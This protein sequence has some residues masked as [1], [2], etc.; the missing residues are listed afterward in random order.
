M[1]YSSSIRLFNYYYFFRY[2]FLDQNQFSGPLPLDWCSPGLGSWWPFDVRSNPALC[3]MVPTCL[4]NRIISLDG[5]SL[6]DPYSKS[7]T[8][9]GGHCGVPPLHCSQEN[10]CSVQGPSPPYWTNLTHVTFSFTEFSTVSKVGKP[11]SYD[12]KLGTYPGGGDVV[13]WVPYQGHTVTQDVEVSS[14]TG[15][16]VVISQVVHVAHG[17]LPTGIALRQGAQ[18]YVA[19]RGYNKA[20]P[21]QGLT[22]VSQAVSVDSTP[23]EQA[24]GGAVYNTQF[25]SDISYQNDT[26][27]I[28]FSWDEFNDPESGLVQYAYQVFEYVLPD[29]LGPYSGVHAGNALINKLTLR[30]TAPRSI[31][32]SKLNLQR[33]KSYFVRLYARNG[34]GLESVKYV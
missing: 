1:F 23:P 29:P 24:A 27:G 6:I 15:Q 7:V 3:G 26:H 20:G 21:L 25:F 34:A 28:G 18:Y 9:N 2:V 19:V 13:N 30:P 5:T 4:A 11:I 12:W 16:L 31:Y 32:I 17:S 14:K 10:G 22:I 33:G 8:E